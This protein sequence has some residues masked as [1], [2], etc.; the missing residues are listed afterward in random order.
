MMGRRVAGTWVTKDWCR[1]QS[2]S[3]TWVTPRPQAR[4]MTWKTT[5]P[6]DERVK[7]IA[8]YLRGERAVSRLC[9]AFGV[10]RKT[11]YKWIARYSEGGVAELVERSRRPHAHPK[12]RKSTRLNSSH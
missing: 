12:D 7:F 6:M 4:R 8:A 2:T 1:K 10:S 9:D 5:C 3:G 11:A